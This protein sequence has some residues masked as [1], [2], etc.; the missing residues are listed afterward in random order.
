M[1]SMAAQP[2]HEPS[3]V[4]VLLV[5]HGTRSELGRGQFLSLAEAVQQRLNLPLEP[6]FLELSE[7]TI[8]QAVA[9]LT[10]GP[11]DVLVVSPM[12]LFAAGH[13][14]QD[15]PS[16]VAVALSRCGRANL[17]L[18]QTDPYGCHPLVLE[19]AHRRLVESL[20]G[21][22]AVLP[23]RTLLIAV[24]R[25]SSDDAATAEMRR[26]ACR[27]A[28]RAS[29]PNVQVVFLALAKPLLAQVLAKVDLATISR[30]IVQP[31]LLFHGELVERLRRQVDEIALQRPDQEWVVTKLL[32]DDGKDAAESGKLLSAATV[33]LINLALHDR[34]S[35]PVASSTLSATISGSH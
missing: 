31:H 22:C 13:A 11:I 23:E 5:G 17:P 20:A 28:E 19:L 21:R 25:G 12:L 10:A 8:E 4:G 9:R 29:I 1:L 18:R 16:A 32:A 30:V 34:A 3:R 24:G 2:A 27:L 35:V 33:N 14:K 7:P 6:A 15:I 26:F